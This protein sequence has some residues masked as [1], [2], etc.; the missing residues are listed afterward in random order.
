MYR[1]LSNY[2]ISVHHHIILG[3]FFSLRF[4]F[5]HQICYMYHHLPQSWVFFLTKLYFKMWFIFFIF[6]LYTY[7]CGYLLS[8]VYTYVVIFYLLFIPMWLFLIFCLYLCGYFWSFVY[9]WAKIDP[10]NCCSILTKKLMHLIL[11]PAAYNVLSLS[12]AIYFQRDFC[13]ISEEM[14]EMY[15]TGNP[16]SFTHFMRQIHKKRTMYNI[17]LQRMKLCHFYFL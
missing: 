11:S 5:K 16:Q 14:N 8:F 10:C 13:W 9:T 1:Q 15:K 7:L 17:L 6:C 4:S 3:A 12:M 2:R